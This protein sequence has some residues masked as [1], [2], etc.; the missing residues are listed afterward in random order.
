MTLRTLVTICQMVR[1]NIS[2]K[3]KVNSAALRTSNPAESSVLLNKSFRN[4]LC[5]I[6]VHWR[7]Y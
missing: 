4:C 1:R 7:L 5:Y 2:G 3:L 6:A